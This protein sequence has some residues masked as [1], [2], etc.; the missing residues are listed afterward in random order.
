MSDPIT[1][2]TASGIASGLA[3]FWSMEASSWVKSFFMDHHPKAIEKAEQNTSDFLIELYNRVVQLEKKKI[4]LK[5]VLEDPDFSAAFQKAVLAS[6]QTSNKEKHQI[7]AELLAQ[8][9]TVESE[10]LLALTTK[11]SLDV[12]SFLTPNQLNIL[13]LFSFIYIVKPGQSLNALNFDTW[14]IKNIDP[15]LDLKISAIDLMHLE[16]LSCLKLNPM[17]KKSLYQTFIDKNNDIAPSLEFCNSE[18]YMKIEKLWDHKLEIIDPKTVGIL[19][20]LNIYNLK[21]K[22]PVN[23]SIFED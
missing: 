15:Y 5:E 14:I 8:R 23:I 7:L 20:G 2:A 3:T 9:L 10:S 1:I 17:I 22:T 12:I 6:A 19:I 13:A 4:D 18:Q 11:M 21:S 16:S